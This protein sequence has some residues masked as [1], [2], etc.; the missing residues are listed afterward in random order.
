MLPTLRYLLSGWMLVLAVLTGSMSVSSATDPKNAHGTIPL[1]MFSLFFLYVA[2]RSSTAGAVVVGDQI[3]FRGPWRSTVVQ[4]SSI[5]DV[6]V[7]PLVASAARRFLGGQSLMTHEVVVQ[8]D[9][10]AEPMRLGPFG[11][12]F[13]SED[14]A[15]RFVERL[16]PALEPQPTAK[17]SPQHSS[18]R[19]RC[20]GARRGPRD[21]F[22]RIL[23]R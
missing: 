4:R 8:V 10:G 1:M 19:T 20:H 7:E 17:S 9:D 11:I 22:D 13:P 2:W 12:A 16:R 6:R 23:A 5:N 18:R 15:G 21:P 3:T 14:G